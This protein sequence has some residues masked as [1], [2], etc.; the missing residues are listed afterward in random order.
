MPKRAKG[1][2]AVGLDH[3][4]E[5]RHADG[6]GLY[7]VITPASRTWAFRYQRAGKRH[8]MGLGGMKGLSLAKARK[9]AKA[10]AD[11]VAVGIDPIEARAAAEAE[12]NAPPPS[13]P[14]TFAEAVQA[15]IAQH[16][17][18]WRSDKTLA[19]WTNTLVNHAGPQL[20]ALPVAEIGRDH[21][22]AVLQPLW[23][24]NHET[25]RK[26]RARIA[27]VIDFAMAK[28]W[29]PE[30]LN[31][32]RW[33]GNLDKLLGRRPVEAATKHY[34][35]LPWEQMPAFMAALRQRPA[36]AAR[37][38]ELVVYSACRSNE[39]CGALWGEMDLDRG[40]WTIP[41]ARAKAGMEHRVALAPAA[42][43]MLRQLLPDD[44]KPAAAD[45]VFR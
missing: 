44:D 18:T 4:P 28:D 36:M 35:A 37:M 10:A 41:A 39:A 19:A 45:P 27:S 30:G 17:P 11:L 29:R 14:T 9:A 26:A 2:S 7:A 32:A 13:A 42:V 5:G 12:K 15:Y 22:L 25:A 6:G 21:V 8:E 3:L 20:G 24:E 43:A 1:L 38:L 31:P 16:A 34:P 33:R 40:V 23:H